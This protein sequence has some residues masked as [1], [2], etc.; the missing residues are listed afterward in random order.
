[1]PSSP[2]L[3]F[4]THGRHSA[5]AAGAAF[6]PHSD[7]RQPDV[8]AQLGRKL[9]LGVHKSAGFAVCKNVEIK[10]VQVYDLD[11]CEKF[12]YRRAGFV[13]GT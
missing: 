9:A 5:L 1:M 12:E 8:E 10:S 2:A 11:V 6:L 13:G 4:E 3:L 7:L